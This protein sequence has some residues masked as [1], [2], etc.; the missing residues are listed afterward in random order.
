MGNERKKIN[1]APCDLPVYNTFVEFIPDV[2]VRLNEVARDLA[3]VGFVLATC[4][5]VKYSILR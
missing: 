4:L 5:M 3:G 1:A 2:Q